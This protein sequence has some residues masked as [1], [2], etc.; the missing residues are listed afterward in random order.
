C[1]TPTVKR[2]GTVFGTVPVVIR[3]GSGLTSA[4]LT[5]TV[6]PPPPP[7]LTRIA[8]TSAIAGSAPFTLHA[9]GSNFT[10]GAVILWAGT[11]L[12][13]TRI[14]STELTAPVTPAAS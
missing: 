10:T 13:T 12:T 8:P 2:A 14:G 11:A 1:V 7:V 4:T 5:F 9:Y 3:N 6:T